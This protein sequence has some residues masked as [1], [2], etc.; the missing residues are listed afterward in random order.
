VVAAVQAME[1]ILPRH[2]AGAPDCVVHVNDPAGGLVLRPPG[3]G[4]LEILYG[5][6][7]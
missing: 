1:A 5:P 3:T 4:E 6:P 7:I 2:A